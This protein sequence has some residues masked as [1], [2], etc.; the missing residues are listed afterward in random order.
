MSLI[1]VRP[2]GQP[3]ILTASVTYE[4]SLRFVGILVEF[5]S[6]LEQVELLEEH[7]EPFVVVKRLQVALGLAEQQDLL[8]H[9]NRV[10]W[11]I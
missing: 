4:A 2:S 3:A 6:L 5:N 7:L 9:F 10:S 8:E 11:V 1:Y